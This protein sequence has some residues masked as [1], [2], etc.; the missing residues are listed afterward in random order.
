MDIEENIEE[1]SQGMKFIQ[2]PIGP[3]VSPTNST[4]GL[5]QP[6]SFDDNLRE[7]LGQESDQISLKK[8]LWPEAEIMKQNDRLPE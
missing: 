3:I 8:M 4:Y 2:T 1:I 6:R 7:W 5:E